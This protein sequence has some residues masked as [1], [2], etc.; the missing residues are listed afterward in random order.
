MI[1]ELVG[2]PTKKWLKT[3][4]VRKLLNISPGTIQTLRTNGTLPYKK[5][6][7]IIYYDIADIQRMLDAKPGKS[8]NQ[9]QNTAH[10]GDRNLL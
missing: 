1:K 8:D 5:I 9:Y 4:E 2:Q 6:G 3:H 7:H 10:G